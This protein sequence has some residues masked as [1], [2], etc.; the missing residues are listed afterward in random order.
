MMDM[1]VGKKFRLGRQIGSGSFGVIHLGT[2]MASGEQV[3]IK[4]ER[5]KTT[6][7]QLLYESKIYRSLRGGGTLGCISK[8]PDMYVLARFAAHALLYLLHTH[9]MYYL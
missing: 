2:H 6:H 3:A 1:Q 7:P 8:F 5:T 4:L 9:T